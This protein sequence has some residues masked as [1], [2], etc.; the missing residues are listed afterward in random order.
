MLDR[1]LDAVRSALDDLANRTLGNVAEE[2]GV[3][4]ISMGGEP[5]ATQRPVVGSFFLWIRRSDGKLVTRGS[6]G[7]D[8][9]IGTP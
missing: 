1:A 8:T 6:N 7:T 3:W 9:V 5:A 2:N 4:T